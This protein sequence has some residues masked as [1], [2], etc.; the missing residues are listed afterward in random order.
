MFSVLFKSDIFQLNTNLVAIQKGKKFVVLAYLISSAD[1]KNTRSLRILSIFGHP[2][3][4]G[5]REEFNM[6]MKK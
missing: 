2:I 1:I 4:W 6:K 5:L 3:H